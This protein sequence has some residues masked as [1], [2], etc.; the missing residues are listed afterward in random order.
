MKCFPI[1]VINTI[2]K[3]KIFQFF[4]VSLYLH[5]H[6]PNRTNTHSLTLALVFDK[7][8]SLSN[9]WA[10]YMR[11]LFSFSLMLWRSE[12]E[13]WTLARIMHD[14]QA[15]ISLC[16]F[17]FLNHL[18]KLR[19]NTFIWS[20]FI[21]WFS[22]FS[23]FVIIMGSLVRFFSAAAVAAVASSSCL[24]PFC[25]DYVLVVAVFSSA[26]SLCAY[27]QFTNSAGSSNSSNRKSSNHMKDHPF[28][29]YIHIVII[30]RK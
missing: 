25:C 23:L 6:R 30:K 8:C 20:F 22:L 7:Q 18:H 24:L 29:A 4:V 11:A 3:R 27:L 15:M 26:Y 2:A 9:L 10:N 19:Y 17:V 28:I 5:V 13:K 12:W 14:K 21:R 16:V 1:F